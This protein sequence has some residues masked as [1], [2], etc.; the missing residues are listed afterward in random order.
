[1][2]RINQLTQPFVLSSPLDRIPLLTSTFPSVRHELCRNQ[3]WFRPYQDC[4]CVANRSAEGRSN[5]FVFVSPSFPRR[6]LLIRS[7]LPSFQICSSRKRLPHRVRRPSQRVLRCCLSAGRERGL[8][9]WKGRMVS[10]L[11][12]SSLVSTRADSILG[13]ALL[14]RYPDERLTRAQTLKG[15]TLDAAYASF[16]ENITVRRLSFSL[17]SSLPFSPLKHLTDPNLL[18]SCCLIIGSAFPGLPRARETSRLRRLGSRHQPRRSRP[19]SSSQGP[20]HRHRRS[21]CFRFTLVD[22]YTV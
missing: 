14:I 13:F 6:R 16:S 15:M 9:S 22:A 3:D 12:S 1:M 8:A 4:L 10:T 20:S 7:L 17:L 5:R 21:T 2:L 18:F 11:L 19:N